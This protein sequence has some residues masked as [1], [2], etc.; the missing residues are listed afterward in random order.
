[1]DP[2]KKPLGLPYLGLPQT[3][4]MHVAA[5][6]KHAWQKG[7]LTPDLTVLGGYFMGRGTLHYVPMCYTFHTLQGP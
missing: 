7:E 5:S 3:F 6:P 4:Q 2:V 1:M